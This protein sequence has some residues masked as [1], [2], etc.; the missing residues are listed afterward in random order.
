[1]SLFKVWKSNTI[2]A[3][4]YRINSQLR[5]LHLMKPHSLQNYLMSH[6]TSSRIH[7]NRISFRDQ[8]VG[9]QITDLQVLLLEVGGSVHHNSKTILKIWDHRIIHSKILHSWH[10]NNWLNKYQN[11][12][13]TIKN[14]LKKITR[15]KNSL[16]TLNKVIK[17]HIM[18]VSV[19]LVK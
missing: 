4:I 11:L 3:K 10:R 1:M 8:W 13:K 18:I 2:T 6:K 12:L 9:V 15:M 16:Q 17:S 7:R 14:I 19:V 5:E